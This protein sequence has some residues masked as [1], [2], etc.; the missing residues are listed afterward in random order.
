MCVLCARAC[1]EYSCEILRILHKFPSTS[2][3][4]NVYIRTF[5]IKNSTKFLNYTSVNFNFAKIIYSCTNLL[6]PIKDP[7]ARNNRN[8]LLINPTD[9]R[10]DKNGRFNKC[11]LNVS[12]HPAIMLQNYSSWMYHSFAYSSL[13]R[14]SVYCCRMSRNPGIS[15]FRGAYSCGH[16]RSV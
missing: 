15:S 1:V 13:I 16:I 8:Y 11:D 6:M 14:Y 12:H 7:S 10:S 5:W 2:I 4:I 3:H 9:D